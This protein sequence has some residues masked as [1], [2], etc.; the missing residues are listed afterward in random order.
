MDTLILVDVLDAHGMMLSRQRL[1]LSLGG[2]PL[3]IGRDIACDI[4]VNDPYSAPRHAGLA[5]REDGAAVVTDLGTINGLIV[6]DERVSHAV[7]AGTGFSHVQVGH[8][9]LRFR[10]GSAGL[11]PERPDRESLRSRYL[12]YGVAALGAL[13]CL[14]FAGFAAWVHAP[15]DV[16]GDFTGRVLR[17]GVFVAGWFAFWVLLG[18][19]VRSR[20]QWAANAAIVLGAAG[21]GLWLWWG[22]GVAVFASGESR[23]VIL[24]GA[25]L[26]LLLGLS[27]YLQVRTA[28][29]LQRHQAA[30][31]ACSILLV[32]VITALGY[33]Q[34]QEAADVNHITPPARIFPPAWSRQPGMRVDKFF[35]EGLDLRA[36]ADQQRVAGGAD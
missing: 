32:A 36:V 8:S 10:L 6:G 25:L 9:Q 1:T 7:I 22:T 11:E 14:A 13:L 17:G 2:P 29:R 19:A 31:V 12:E 27:V 18:R 20:W 34:R 15:D 24:G 28:T 26:A 4:V 35:E 33:R 23:L 30:A 16:A 3:T 21:A 5:L